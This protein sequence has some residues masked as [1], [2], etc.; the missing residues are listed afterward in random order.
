MNKDGSMMKKES[1]ENRETWGRAAPAHTM[2]S[3][4]YGL[5]KDGHSTHACAQ[6]H[7]PL[8]LCCLEWEK[9]GREGSRLA[10]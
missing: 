4:H 10:L 7:T 9:G 8:R 2:L 6:A 1:K 5:S 3:I